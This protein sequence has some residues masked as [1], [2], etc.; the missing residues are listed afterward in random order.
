MKK[1]MKQHTHKN[2]EGKNTMEPTKKLLYIGALLAI[3]VIIGA[4]IVIGGSGKASA[5]K[6]VSTTTSETSKDVQEVTLTF[7]NYEYQLSPPQLRQGVPV[8]MTVDLST[9]TGCMRSIVI[10]SFNV[11]QTVSSGDNIITFTPDKAGTFNIACSMNMGRGT[12]TVVNELGTTTGFIEQAAAPTAGGSCGMA[13][14][15]C[16]CGAKI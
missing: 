11:K 6:V 8:R 9:V 3:T 1:E 10:P 16:G 13:G 12:F 2:Q 5:E 7:K 14:G 4:S 15:G